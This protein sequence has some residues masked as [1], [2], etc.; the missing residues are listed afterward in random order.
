MGIA[1]ERDLLAAAGDLCSAADHLRAVGLVLLAEEIDAFLATLEGEMR[2]VSKPSQQHQVLRF[3]KALEQQ[4][5]HRAR[6]HQ[7]QRRHRRDL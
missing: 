4:Q 6:H 5:Q 3:Q 1:Q 2:L 7:H